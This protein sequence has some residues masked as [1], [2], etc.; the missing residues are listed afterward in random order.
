MAIFDQDKQEIGFLYV[1]F[2]EKVA[3]QPKIMAQI[4]QNEQNK[5]KFEN[6]QKSSQGHFQKIFNKFQDKTEK[7][8]ENVS[9]PSSESENEA[10]GS[11]SDTSDFDTDSESAKTPG[12]RS[13]LQGILDSN[14]SKAASENVKV[15]QKSEKQA[16]KSEKLTI[17]SVKKAQNSDSPPNEVND[18]ANVFLK[19][20]DTQTSSIQGVYEETVLSEKRTLKSEKVEKST[21]KSTVKSSSKKS[22]A[23]IVGTEKS[24]SE[25]R[26]LLG[27]TNEDYRRRLKSEISLIKAKNMK[28][29]VTGEKSFSKTRSDFQSFENS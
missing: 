9:L 12:D 13:Q 5:G 20:I 15:S 16:P 21:V 3:E 22:R 10:S 2:L 7:T 8:A 24:T 17:S 4:S 26:Q 14:Q 1:K 18:H 19:I 29:E 6:P 28:T 27:I 11:D 23:Q 25:L